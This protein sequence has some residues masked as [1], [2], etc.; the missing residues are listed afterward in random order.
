VSITTTGDSSGS[1]SQRT[2]LLRSRNPSDRRD[3]MKIKSMNKALTD[4]RQCKKIA[5]HRPKPRTDAGAPKKSVRRDG[6]PSLHGVDHRSSGAAD[7]ASGTARFF[8]MHLG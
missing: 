6:L 3:A 8:G 1:P 5:I 4:P 2:I 7:S